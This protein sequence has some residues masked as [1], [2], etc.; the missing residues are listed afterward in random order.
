MKAK[1]LT[2]RAPTLT[3]MCLSVVFVAMAN[4]D[5]R[6]MINCIEDNVMIAGID[7]FIENINDLLP[8][9]IACFFP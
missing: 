6:T 8:V 5:G 4:T 2:E 9:L 1:S 7:C 3:P